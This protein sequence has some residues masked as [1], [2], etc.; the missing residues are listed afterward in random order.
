MPIRQPPPIALHRPPD[1][2]LAALLLSGLLLALAACTTPGPQPTQPEPVSAT[3]LIDQ[4]IASG[5]Y[6]GAAEAY[7]A[8]A[9]QASSPQRELLTLS[10]IDYLT[11]AQDFA[12]AEQ[13]FNQLPSSGD[14]LY[15]T[16]YT[17][18]QARLQM[19]RGD[20]QAALTT[21]AGI[22]ER[23]AAEYLA[24]YHRTRAE[25]YSLAGNLLESARERIWLDGLLPDDQRADNHQAIWQTLAQLPDF[26]L[27]GLRTA[28]PP[29]TLSG[30]MELVQTTRAERDDPQQLQQALNLW[31]ERYPGHPAEP[32]F[33][34]GIVGR[35]TTL[36]AQPGQIALLLPLTGQFQEAG[37]ALRDGIMAA[38][39]QS[40]ERDRITLRVYDS[41]VG[42]QQIWGL[43]QRAI[44]DGAE[45]VIGP[46]TKEAVAE[47]AR[48]GTL[49]IPVLALNAIDNTGG[50]PVNLYQYSLSPEDEAQQVADRAWQDGHRTAL[51]LLP[52]G[53]WGE[54]ILTAFAARWEALGG[55]LLEVRH[56]GED[57]RGYS[58]N[59]RDL[60]NIDA[61]ERRQQALSRLIGQQPEF[62]PRRRQD[63]DFVFLIAYPQQGRLLRPLL[64]FH[65]ASRLPVYS[66]SQ[67]YSGVI[68]ADLDRDL[69]G[70]RFCDMPWM[71]QSE[72]PAAALRGEIGRYWPER[73]QRYTRLYAMG[74]DAFQ[75]TRYVL[76]LGDGIFA[77]HP[78]V[79]G[80]LYLDSARQVHR[81]LQ[82]AQFEAGSPRALPPTAPVE[83]YEPS[84]TDSLMD[85]QE[86]MDDFPVLEKNPGKAHNTAPGSAR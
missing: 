15:S 6:R 27:Q 75:L 45:M 25:A 42:S 33:L 81:D 60:L 47:L 8:Q 31:R 4:R 57:Q 32:E 38:Y 69:D 9:A 16:R 51:A 17:L 43:Y 71:L 13:L 78:G 30:W 41:G 56:Y 66:T 28:P 29:D 3:S 10:A 73:E 64:R 59:V 44:G 5:D 2:S 35:V 70:L 77:R 12:A 85:P 76:G 62:E 11:R 52:D 53:Q 39:L 18:A 68:N 23:V 34:A 20:P 72:H 36:G 46:L 65:R 24:D 22:S 74:I 79:T 14:N 37:Q 80:D 49:E 86:R 50:F 63:A 54:R 48:A 83:L 67:I 55:T 84:A 82:W 19:G 61:S 40:D 7:L 26:V 1:R 58:N 21:L